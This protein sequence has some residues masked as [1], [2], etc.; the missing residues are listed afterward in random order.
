MGNELSA[1]WNRS[2]GVALERLALSTKAFKRV[3]RGEPASILI[4]RL[5]GL[6][7]SGDDLRRR[8]ESGKQSGIKEELQFLLAGLTDYSM[9]ASRIGIRNPEWDALQARLSEA[10]KAIREF[11]DYLIGAEEPLRAPDPKANDSNQD[12]QRIINLQ[13]SLKRAQDSLGRELQ[14]KAELKRKNSDLDAQSRNLLKSLTESQAEVRRQKD[15]LDKLMAERSDLVTQLGRIRKALS[16]SQA[17][18]Q[19]QAWEIKTERLEMEALS[20]S[21][22]KTLAETQ[23]RVE[24]LVAEL[25]SLRNENDSLIFKA[26]ELETQVR[27]YREQSEHESELAQIEVTT[28]PESQD[29]AESDQEKGDQS[30]DQGPKARSAKKL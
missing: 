21:R 6:C 16:E 26:N 5:I 2:A 25:Q 29:G 22:K 4:E 18:V 3:R 20:E 30:S 11:R 7:K 1:R 23:T 9:D 14:E 8:I 12:Q 19:K 17:E 27:T 28:A 24:E 10:E 13:A 15:E